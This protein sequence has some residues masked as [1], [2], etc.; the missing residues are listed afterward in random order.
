MSV[1]LC[2]LE[3]IAYLHWRTLTLLELFFTVKNWED[4]RR[5]QSDLQAWRLRRVF[6]AG[7]EP[8]SRTRTAKGH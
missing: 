6:V 7:A 5:I 8:E 1:W 3:R 4:P 2:E